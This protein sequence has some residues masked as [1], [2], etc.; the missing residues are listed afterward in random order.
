MSCIEHVLNRNN[1]TVNCS[2]VSVVRVTLTHTKRPR[3]S[4]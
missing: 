1:L 3:G 2:D 4:N